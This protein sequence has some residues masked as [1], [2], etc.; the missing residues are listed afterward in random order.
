MTK[1]KKNDKAKKT[2]ETT[3]P[4]KGRDNKGRFIA[5]N[6]LSVGNSGGYSNPIPRS[7]YRLKTNECMG[8][9]DWG[10]TLERIKKILRSGEDSDVIR[11]AQ[12]L[13]KVLGLDTVTHEVTGVGGGPLQLSAETFRPEE[14]STEE[15][16]KIA[17]QGRE[18]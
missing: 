11:A 17:M 18:E 5:G 6:Q 12:F 9:D 10:E 13:A 1:K 2:S 7:L 8:L 14:L 16:R 15:L 3:E 4:K